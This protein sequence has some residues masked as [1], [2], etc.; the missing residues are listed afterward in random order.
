MAEDPKANAV[1]EKYPGH[2]NVVLPG[3][4]LH[5]QRQAWQTNGG[6]PTKNLSPTGKFSERILPEQPDVHVAIGGLPKPALFPLF[7]REFVSF[8]NGISM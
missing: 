3:R 7:G 2:P 6:S 1:G 5:A 8:C 4:T